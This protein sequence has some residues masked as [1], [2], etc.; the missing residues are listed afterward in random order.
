MVITYYSFEAVW[1]DQWLWRTLRKSCIE[2]GY[3]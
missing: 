1:D 2:E 3:A